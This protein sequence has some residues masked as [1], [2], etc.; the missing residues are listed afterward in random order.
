[1]DAIVQRASNQTI[2]QPNPVQKVPETSYQ[3]T[4]VELPS[5]GRLGYSSIIE[6]REIMVS[7]EKAIANA[8]ELTFFTTLNTVL[9]SLLKDQSQFEDMSLF[10]RDF[11]L[12]WIWANNYDTVK[13]VEHECGKCGGANNYDIDVTELEIDEVEDSYNDAYIHK[14]RSGKQ[15][16]LKLL[17]VRDEQAAQEYMKRIGKNVVDEM[18]VMM[19]LSIVGTKVMSVADRIKWVESEFTG[20]DI[21]EVRG[22]HEYFKFGIADS[23]KRTCTHCG[24]GETISIPFQ[25]DHFI[26]TIKYNFR[27]TV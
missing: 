25:V 13:H 14:F 3:F 23:V 2:A 8:T 11:L 26:P 24:E 21:A 27:P 16:G 20:K 4:S 6:Y 22:F 17:T 1:M 10:D 12:M 9:K 18:Y 15:F 5:N 7:D 19:C